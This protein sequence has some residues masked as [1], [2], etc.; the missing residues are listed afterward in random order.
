G[1]SSRECSYCGKFFRSNYYLNIH[2]RTHTG[3][4][5]YKCEF[6]EYAAAQKTS[7]RYHLE[8]H[9]K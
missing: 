4:K 3:E 2:L 8:R 7:L 6:C 9:H 1:S 5:P